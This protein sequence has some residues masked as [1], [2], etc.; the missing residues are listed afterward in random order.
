M[1]RR[2]PARVRAS[3]HPRRFPLNVTPSINGLPLYLVAAIYRLENTKNYLDPG[4]VSLA[5]RHWSGFV[6]SPSRRAWWEE[7]SCGV[8]EC[9]PD[10]YEARALL[11]AVAYGLSQRHAREFRRYLAALDALL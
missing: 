3:S 6:R 1:P 4:E 5:I 9:F 2:P 11:E 10:P 8:R 7:S